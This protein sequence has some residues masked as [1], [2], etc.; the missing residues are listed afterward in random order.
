MSLQTRIWHH[1]RK[2]FLPKTEKSRRLFCDWGMQKSRLFH[3]CVISFTK[4]YFFALKTQITFIPGGKCKK[5]LNFTFLTR[6]K[7]FEIFSSPKVKIPWTT[8]KELWAILWFFCAKSDFGTKV[9]EFSPKSEDEGNWSQKT[10]KTVTFIKG[11]RH[12]G[13]NVIS[14]PK[15]EKYW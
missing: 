2:Y 13:G 11:W 15:S 5:W 12:G 14:C 6:K 3:F 8:F 4:R 10:K 9:V 7:A 1:I